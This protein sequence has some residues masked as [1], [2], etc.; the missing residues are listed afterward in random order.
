ML[1]E[2]I[3]ILK[4]EKV[5]ISVDIL[6]HRLKVDKSALEGMLE[7]LIKKDIIKMDN[8]WNVQSSGCQSFSCQGCPAARG[9]PFTSK[10]PR[11][12][13]LVDFKR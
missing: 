12:Y 5:S 6:S 13:T 10:M 8:G 3:D 11:T 4:T 2:I 1:R 7:T 9:C